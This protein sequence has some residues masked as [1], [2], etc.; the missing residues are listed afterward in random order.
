ML[1]CRPDHPPNPFVA[2]GIKSVPT[3]MDA[4]TTHY[5]SK[6][7]ADQEIEMHHAIA[8]VRS[9]ATIMLLLT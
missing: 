1:T 9:H 3:K 6:P 4:A 8:E 7:I 5:W 2:R